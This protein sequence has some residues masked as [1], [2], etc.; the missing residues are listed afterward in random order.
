M[1]RFVPLGKPVRRFAFLPVQ[2]IESEFGGA[3][4]RT[5][6]LQSYYESAV[7][8]HGGRLIIQTQTAKRYHHDWEL[9]LRSFFAP[10]F[11]MEYLN[12]LCVAHNINPDTVAPRD[13]LARLRSLDELSTVMDMDDLG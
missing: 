13:L 2:I 3:H 7:R 4:V 6:W 10:D 5:I 8:A 9:S 1:A 12:E 11:D